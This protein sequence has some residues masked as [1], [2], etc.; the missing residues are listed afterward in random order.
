[1]ERKKWTPQTYIT[2]TL[3]KFREKRKWQLALRRYVIEKNISANYAHYFG[4]T[5]ED[6]REWIK[7]QFTSGLNWQNFGSDWQFDHI[8]PVAYFDFSIEEDLLLCWNFINIR[9]DKIES[10]K[11]VV[12]RIDILSAKPYFESLFTA[13]GYPLCLK[14]VEKINSLQESN[15]ENEPAI[16][17]FILHNLDKLSTLASLEKEE[18]NRLNTG[19][20]LADILKEKELFKKFG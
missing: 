18:F 11:N 15:I 17:H 13:T 9:V 14:M 1:M 10:D 2:E 4:L 20:S 3:L 16:E 6:F 8:V 7:I 19:T 5:I 12:K